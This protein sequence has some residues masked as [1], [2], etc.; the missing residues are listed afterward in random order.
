MR[1]LLIESKK[2]YSNKIINLIYI[3][4]YEGFLSIYNESKS[5]SN[6][7]NILQLF[8]KFL[9]K[10]QDWDDTILNRENARIFSSNSDLIIKILKAITKI[11]LKILT[12][13]SDEM[14]INNKTVNNFIHNIYKLVAIVIW[15]NPF[16]FYHD[17]EP[18]ILK[19]NQREVYN[20]IKECIY[21]A[22]DEIIDL[23]SIVDKFLIL[24]LDLEEKQMEELLLKVNNLE[25]KIN[26]LGIS[27]TPK[28]LQN[29]GNHNISEIL[30]NNNVKISDSNIN[31]NIPNIPEPL[32]SIDNK[33]I[34]NKSIENKSIEN[35]SINYNQQN[36]GNNID[37]NQQN[38]GNTDNTDKTIDSKIENII[39]KDLKMT[40]DSLTS[41][42][43]EDGKK[44]YKP[45]ESEQYQE[46]FSNSEMSKTSANSLN[47]VQKGENLKRNKFFS[48]Y[49]NF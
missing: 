30:N 20:I 43:E 33:S 13:S 41:D 49:L 35:K 12:N 36:G 3:K 7:S 46:V 17:L 9:K 31:G 11:N 34:E 15:D 26:I 2:I 27:Q 39:E 14:E 32:Y 19:K 5:I 1:N 40:E 37:N 18:E 22:I 28:I 48:N 47:S 8:Q 23:S 38:G 44:S 10:I 16:L 21:R 25:N 24:D 45:E 6:G 42:E 29:G 4:I